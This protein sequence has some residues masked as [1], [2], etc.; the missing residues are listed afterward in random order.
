MLDTGSDMIDLSTDAGTHHIY[1]TFK[2]IYVQLPSGARD[3]I[4]GVKVQLHPH[5]MYARINDWRD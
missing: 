4:F 2:P 1:V 3:L 5:F